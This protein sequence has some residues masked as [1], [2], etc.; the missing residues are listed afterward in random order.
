[1]F[2]W[3]RRRGWGEQQPQQA[4]MLA[5]RWS[6]VPSSLSSSAEGEAKMDLNILCDIRHPWKMQKKNSCRFPCCFPW[7]FNLIWISCF[8]FF[9]TRCVQIERRREEEGSWGRGKN[10]VSSISNLPRYFLFPS[11]TLNHVYGQ[12]NGSDSDCSLCFFIGSFLGYLLLSLQD[13]CSFF[14]PAFLP[15]SNQAM[16]LLTGYKSFFRKPTLLF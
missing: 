1:M 9:W 10:K 8:M 14:L 16:G 5:K 15:H 7:F 3:W 2:Q 4:V 13:A 12:I 6:M 11:Y